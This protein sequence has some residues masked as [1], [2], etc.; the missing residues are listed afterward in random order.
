M[1]GPA[2]AGEE[3]LVRPAMCSTPAPGLIIRVPHRATRL[4]RWWRSLLAPRS[5]SAAAAAKSICGVGL[6]GAVRR[7]LILQS[8]GR[9][10]PPDTS[11]LI[12]VALELNR[13]VAWCPHRDALL[14][15]G[16]IDRFDP[17]LAAIGKSD[18]VSVSHG[19]DLN[20][21]RSRSDVSPCSRSPARCTRC[22]S[23]STRRRDCDRHL[24]APTHVW[25][26]CG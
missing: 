23:S 24:L 22:P 12:H 18:Y 6:L 19:R 2:V 5:R 14:S 13:S 17:D 11:A 9:Q 7:V 15:V 20:A 4:A 21:A 10:T 8:R 1:T 16:L 26:S 3:A 25:R